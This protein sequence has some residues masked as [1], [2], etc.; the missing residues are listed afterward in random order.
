[1]KATKRNKIALAVAIVVFILAFVYAVSRLSTVEGKLDGQG[2]STGQ[3]SDTKAT[4]DKWPMEPPKLEV[5][6]DWSTWSWKSTGRYVKV[7]GRLAIQTKEGDI[8][9]VPETAT[10]AAMPK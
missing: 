7:D 8:A 6:S 4:A 2:N 10:T 3:Q 5:M 1:M 9:F